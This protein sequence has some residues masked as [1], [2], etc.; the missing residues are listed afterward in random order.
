MASTSGRWSVPRVPMPALLT[1]PASGASSRARAAPSRCVDRSAT[2]PRTTAPRPAAADSTCAAS[3]SS[4]SMPT[5][6]QP[7][8]SRRSR[9]ARP[10]PC[11]APVTTTL[12]SM[13][14][15]WCGVEQ[16]GVLRIGNERA[17][18][19]LVG[20]GQRRRERTGGGG[21]GRGFGDLRE[22]ARRRVIAL[23]RAATPGRPCGRS[24]DL[25]PRGRARGS[26]SRPRR[27]ACRSHPGPASPRSAPGR[28][29]DRR[30]G[31]PASG[32]A[33][34]DGAAGRTAPRGGRSP[35]CAPCT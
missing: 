14:A 27:S 12:R 10:I 31:S 8:A 7:S 18:A 32:C 20:T 19:G 1:H 34:T 28:G 24:P 3:S 11:P 25:A 13:V 15:P 2:S 35:R 5:T 33:C 23:D 16:P 21:H 22:M 26:G 9:Q 6:N 4:T 17:V 30:R 29:R